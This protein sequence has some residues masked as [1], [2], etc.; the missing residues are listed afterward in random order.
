MLKFIVKTFFIFIFSLYGLQLFAGELKLVRFI[1]NKGQ[2]NSNVLYKLRIN[3]GAMFLENNRI[4]YHFAVEDDLNHLD[5]RHSHKPVPDNLVVRHHA[6]RVNFRNCNNNVKLKNNI[7]FE[8]H[9][10]YYIGDDPSKWASGVKSF[11]E[12]SY[13]NLYNGINLV[14]SEAENRLKYQFNVAALADAKLIQ[15][16]FEGVENIYL[17]EGNLYY[18]TSVNEIKELKPYS[19][20]TINGK[21][22]KVES[23]FVLNGNVVSFQFPNGYN[24]NYPL[25]IDPV[26]IFSS[27]TGSLA[28]NFGFTATYDDAGNLYAGGIARDVGYTTT[29]GAFQSTYAGGVIQGQFLLGFDCD[30]SI[31]KF[32]SDGSV[33]I[34]STYIGG[35][36]NDQPHSL[37]VD[38]DTNLIIIGRTN[39]AD[40]PVSATGFDRTFNGEFDIVVTKLNYD[41][42]ALIGS[43]YIGGISADGVNIFPDP[44]SVGSLKYNYADDSRSEVIVDEQGFIYVAA[45]TQSA[46]FPVTS[47][48]YQPNLA[49]NQ[50]GCIFKFNQDLSSLIWSTYLGGSADDAAYSLVLDTLGNIYTCGGTNSNN[51]PVTNNALNPTFRGGR[52][53]GFIS[54]LN[55]TA[56]ALLNSTY[57][58][59]SGYDQCHFIQLDGDQDVYTFGQTDGAMISTPGTYSNPN[60]GQF[61]Y[62]LTPD[63]N[64]VSFLTTVGGSDGQ[65][66]ISPTAFLVDNCRNIYLCGWGSPIITTTIG[67]LGLPVTS[68]AFQSTTDG[69]D[70]Y[71]MVLSENAGQLLYATYFGGNQSEEH[72][73]GGTSR[74]DKNGIM[75]EAVCAGCGGFNDFPTTPGVVSI[76][77]NSQNPQ[78]NC[79]EGLIKFQI[80]FNSVDVNI[81]TDVVKGCAPLTVNFNSNGFQ[82]DKYVW[83]FGTGDSSILENP[84]YT[85]TQPGTY[86]I[87]LTGRDTSCRDLSLVDSSTYIIIVTNDSIAADFSYVITGDCDSISVSFISQVTN[88][89]SVLWDFGDGATSTELNP[90]HSYNTSGTYTVLFSVTNDSTCNKTVLIGKIIDVDVGFNNDIILEKDSG[91]VRVSVEVS[92]SHSGNGI[93]AQYFWN[94][95]NGAVSTETNPEFTYNTPGTYTISLITVDSSF[96]NI[97]DTSFATITV[98]PNNVIANFNTERDTFEIFELVQF[99]N[100]SLNADS[101]LWEFGDGYNSTIMN[102]KHG[103]NPEGDYTPCLTAYN[104]L[105]CEDS[106][107]KPL[108]IIF[109]GIL[110]VANAFS[111]NGDGQNDIIY[112]KG[113][114]ITELEFRIYNRWGELVFESDDINFGW[115]GTYKGTNQEME[116]YV[117]TLKAKFKNGTESGL[118]KGNITLLR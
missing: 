94:F 21:H 34:Y 11:N 14:F 20:Q 80:A 90:V 85:Y 46:D 95:G 109:R 68:D 36:I 40:Y 45:S 71:F 42:T 33:F 112:V 107:C 23:E 77:N 54:R 16:E 52:A 18:K 32:S 59:T 76:T 56:T 8:G 13:V 72:V 87:N 86:T 25:V 74:F 39:S 103:Y 60:S 93:N 110:D 115:D 4:T 113:Y 9:Y 100:T 19:F 55:P 3:N 114:G 53:D 6:F 2:W 82:T 78:R 26:L 51:F 118:R 64:G 57:I 22:K 83:Y 111:P 98:V 70:F 15:L 104:R 92:S 99:N 47:G 10:N 61:I 97:S 50:D 75:Y 117:Y 105:G 96:C 66:D 30:M 116:V 5:H 62:G 89:D 12:I 88:G 38:K 67:T 37:V 17:K 44:F 102:P 41:G 27:F 106:I 35:S 43:T 49:G 81:T 79:N 101:Y 28:D 48:V 69:A 108:V 1:E 7:Q 91:C 84:T 63:L 73:D 31:S 24:K 65:P 58:G 29:P